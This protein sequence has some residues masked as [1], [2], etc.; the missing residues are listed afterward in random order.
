MRVT[1]AMIEAKLAK[2]IEAGEIGNCRFKAVPWGKQCA[3][4]NLDPDFPG[5]L[6]FQSRQEAY[7]W[8]STFTERNSEVKS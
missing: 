1:S 2:M 7:N 3:I 6:T 8:L 5:K 4:E